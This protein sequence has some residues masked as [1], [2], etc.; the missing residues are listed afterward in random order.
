M[1]TRQIG[2]IL[3]FSLVTFPHSANTFHS[4]GRRGRDNGRSRQMEIFWVGLPVRSKSHCFRK[5]C[6]CWTLLSTIEQ[7]REGGKAI[8]E[9]AA[10]ASANRWRRLVELAAPFTR[11]RC[12]VFLWPIFSCWSRAFQGFDS[13]IAND[14]CW[15]CQKAFS[16][17]QE[18][19][20]ALK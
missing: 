5:P 17:L 4:S 19:R 15:V 3:T 8:T 10:A 13:W 12:L 14:L 9:K 11:Q 18:G 6:G 16:L 1:E 7:G 20:A 2:G